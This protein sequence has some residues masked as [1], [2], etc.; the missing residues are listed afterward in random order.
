MSKALIRILAGLFFFMLVGATAT[1]TLLH[2]VPLNGFG[3]A[4][5]LFIAGGL[6]LLSAPVSDR[7]RLLFIGV[8]GFVAEVIGVKFGWLFGRYTYTPVLAPNVFDVPLAMACAWLVLIGYVRQMMAGLSISVWAEI[9]LGGM[10]MTTI[11]LLSEPLAAHPFNFW[12]WTDT[13]FYYGIPAHNY[14]GW[15][16]VS[17]V[18]L[19]LDKWIF[20]PSWNPNYWVEIVG[21]GIV[22]FCT[23]SALI[24]GYLIAFGVGI[25]LIAIHLWLTKRARLA[26]NALPRKIRSTRVTN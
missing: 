11:D 24:Y 18:I 21:V 19:A 23:I 13:G 14:L 20:K 8:L 26:V 4:S 16:A 1:H 3:S 22:V 25:L 5:F 10:W 6:V 7:A 2:Q 9:L 12:I 17:C 15:F